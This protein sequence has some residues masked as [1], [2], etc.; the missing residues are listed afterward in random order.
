MCLRFEKKTSF[1]LWY[2]R[3]A[4]H[5]HHSINERKFQC[6]QTIYFS[7]EV[8]IS[9]R[10]FHNFFKYFSS[11][12]TQDVNEMNKIEINFLR[13]FIFVFAEVFFFNVCILNSFHIWCKVFFMTWSVHT[14]I[15]SS[16]SCF[17]RRNS[18]S[19]FCCSGVRSTKKY[20]W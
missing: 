10:Y 8:S 5:S 18:M 16:N 11:Y 1:K 6:T 17:F 3:T 12:T 2:K 9:H 7:Q 15:S 20:N 4:S 14:W 19:N 13:L